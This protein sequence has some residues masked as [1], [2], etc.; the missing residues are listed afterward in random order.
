MLKAKINLLGIFGV[1]GFGTLLIF[2]VAANIFINSASAQLFWHSN[3]VLYDRL[4]GTAAFYDTN[5]QGGM[6]LLKTY[7]DWRRS[8]DEIVPPD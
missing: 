7:T 3:L 2:G 5:G 8:W 1:L 6:T 4:N